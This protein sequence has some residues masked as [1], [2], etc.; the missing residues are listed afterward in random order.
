MKIKNIL[1]NVVLIGIIILFMASCVNKEFQNDTFFT[2]ALGERTVEYGIEEFD[3]LVWHENLT[4]I[5]T[6]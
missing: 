6:F 1:I 3:G 2:I 5:H 4:F